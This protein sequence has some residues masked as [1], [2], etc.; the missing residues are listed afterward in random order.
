MHEAENDQ[1]AARRYLAKAVDIRTERC[2]QEP[3]RVDLAE[4]LA[5]TLRQRITLT[6]QIEPGA[7]KI[8]ARLQRFVDDQLITAKGE[9]V[10]AWLDDLEARTPDSQGW[11][12]RWL[13][14]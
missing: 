3:N 11:C 5:T 14:A 13:S 4:E 7:T 8:R 10:L 12:S 1:D 2:E 6:A 9:A